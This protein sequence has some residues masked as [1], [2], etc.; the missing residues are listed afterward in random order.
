MLRM[1]KK[2]L[3]I[4]LFLAVAGYLAFCALVYL[5]PQL[6][7]Y[8]PS[9]ATPRLEIARANGYPAQ[10]VDYKAA[11]GTPLYAWYTPPKPGRPIIVFMHGNS[12][13]I[14]KFYHKLLPLA[15]AGYGTLLP[16]YRGFGGVPGKIT[17]GGLEQDAEAALT[18]LR[19]KGFANRDIV[20]YGMSL[21]SYTATHGAYAL[22]REEPYA[23]LILEVPFDSMY[24]DVRDIVSF[25]L[26]L[27]WIMRDK[28]DNLEKIRQLNLPLLVMGG[29][30]DTLVP[31]RRAEALFAAA[32]QPKKLIVYPGAGH[33]DLYNH[34]NYQDILNWLKANE[35][36][37]H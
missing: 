12:F 25:P 36:A 13:N 19:Q 11:D 21:G 35:K 27:K 2:T 7:F 16:E 6:F 14:E 5:R 22:G 20:L 18:W 17:Q 32:N 3:K 29:Q 33:N 24:E 9:T 37:R 23:G 28:Y 4:C 10:R 26:P 30:D 31:V 34:R 1:L 8:A 15:E